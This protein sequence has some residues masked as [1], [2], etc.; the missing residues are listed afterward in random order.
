MGSFQCGRWGPAT[1]VWFGGYSCSLNLPETF[2]ALSY[3][4]GEPLSGLRFS[5]STGTIR[6]FGCGRVSC[7]SRVYSCPP[8]DGRSFLVDFVLFPCRQDGRQGLK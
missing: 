4:A 1:L 2:S 6:R 8:S 7:R 5:S 3:Q